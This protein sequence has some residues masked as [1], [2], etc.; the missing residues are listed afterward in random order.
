MNPGKMFIVIGVV[1]IVIG[2][3]WSLIGKIPGDFTFKK[4]SVTVY[5]PFMTSIIVSIL[6]TLI[7]FI[8]GK[9]TG[10]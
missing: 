7:F 4:G 10:R 3:L 5:F 6:L 1:L 9:F 8:I 2:L